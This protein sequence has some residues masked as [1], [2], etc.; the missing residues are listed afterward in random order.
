MPEF[1]HSLGRTS[2]STGIQAMGGT[3]AR[4]ISR[5]SEGLPLY[6]DVEMFRLGVGAMQT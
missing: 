1:S 2:R 6:V 5:P 3:G 4:P